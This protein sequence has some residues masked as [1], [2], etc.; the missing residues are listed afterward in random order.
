MIRLLGPPP[1]DFIAKGK[2]SAIKFSPTTVRKAVPTLLPHICNFRLSLGNFCAG[3]PI[4]DRVPLEEK[5]A[6]LQG[7][8]REMFLRFLRRML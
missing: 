5:E 1:P 6:R 4:L 8:D 7:E 2:T 3:I